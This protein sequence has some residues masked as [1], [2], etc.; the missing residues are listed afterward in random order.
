MDKLHNT[1]SVLLLISKTN[2]MGFLL[3]KHAYK[4][5]VILKKNSQGLGEDSVDEL[6]D[7]LQ[8]ENQ[9]CIPATKMTGQYS[10]PPLILAL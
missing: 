4:I 9:S 3:C 6:L 2:I 1:K 10:N 8:S 5:E 7:V